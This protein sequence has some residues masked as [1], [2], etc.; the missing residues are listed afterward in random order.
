MSLY[1]TWNYLEDYWPFAGRLSA[2]NTIGTQLHD[3]INSVLTRCLALRRRTL[4]SEHHHRYA[5]ARPDKL[6]TD[7]MAYVCL[8]VCM[9][10]CMYAWSSHITYMYGHTYS[11]VW[12][13]RIRLPILLVVS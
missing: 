9:Y 7:P 1:A 6:G 10:V 12:I 8:Y 2:V 11:R 5:I 4:G 3:P 13:N